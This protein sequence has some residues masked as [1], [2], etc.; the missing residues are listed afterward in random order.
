MD[1]VP[2]GSLPT[3]PLCLWMNLNLPEAEGSEMPQIKTSQGLSAL[4]S[5]I[6]EN[7]PVLRKFTA[8]VE[9]VTT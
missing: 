1:E 3:L 2:V 6:L 5:H 8:C 7:S 4:F 9:K